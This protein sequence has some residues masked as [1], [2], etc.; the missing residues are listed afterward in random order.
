MGEAITMIFYFEVSL[1]NKISLEDFW[2][3]NNRCDNS[4][5]KTKF[6]VLIRKIKPR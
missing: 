5:T 4:Q 2:V 3:L 1:D 6:H